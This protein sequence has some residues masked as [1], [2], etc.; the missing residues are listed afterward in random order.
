MVV[1]LRVTVFTVL[2]IC[3]LAVVTRKGDERKK[4]STQKY[5]ANR[6]YL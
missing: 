2:T 4:K 6:M 1:L 5:R 3:D